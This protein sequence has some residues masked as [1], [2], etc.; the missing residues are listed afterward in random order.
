[1]KNNHITKILSIAIISICLAGLSTSCLKIKPNGTKSAKKYFETFFVGEEGTQYFIKPFE[2]ANDN[3]E[4][5]LLDITFRYKDEVK[6]SA[7]LTFTYY[8]EDLIKSIDSLSFSNPSMS[9]QANSIELLFNERDKDLIQSRFSS[10]VLLKDLVNLFDKSNWEI[11]LNSSD[12]PYSVSSNKKSDKIIEAL[13]F[14]IFS[15]F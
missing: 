6:D 5:I 2:F 12:K 10:K 13:N 9:L 3:G 15:L 1:M 11:K 14:E 7:T 8:S 4:K